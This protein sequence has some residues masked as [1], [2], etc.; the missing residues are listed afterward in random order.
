MYPPILDTLV[1]PPQSSIPLTF[2][3]ESSCKFEHFPLEK[4]AIDYLVWLLSSK[5]HLKGSNSGGRPELRG[6][7]SESSRYFPLRFWSLAAMMWDNIEQFS[8][9]SSHSPRRRECGGRNFPRWLVP[10]ACVGPFP[11]GMAIWND[12]PHQNIIIN[13]SETQEYTLESRLHS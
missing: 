5:F 4:T 11:E 12:S 3:D 7:I 6:A 9:C 2:F 1:P 10:P 8:R 13:T